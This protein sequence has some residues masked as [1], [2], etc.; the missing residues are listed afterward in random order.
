MD[1]RFAPPPAALPRET[2]RAILQQTQPAWEAPDLL[3]APP[4]RAR[5]PWLVVAA[6]VIL[7]LGAMGLRYFV[8]PPRV[9]PISL[10]VTEKDGQLEIQWNPLAK[11][12]NGATRGSLAIVDGKDTRTVPL[13]PQDLSR[14]SYAYQRTSGDV[15]VR[16]A[17]E[18][19]SGE[20]TEEAS[21]Y[22]GRPLVKEDS[23]ELKSL[24]QQR[25]D[26]QAEVQ[27]LRQENAT[28]NE[29]IQQL[30]RTLRILQ[31]RLGVK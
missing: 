16:L 10:A 27:R 19:A 3:P 29:R 20:K 25:D 15:E 11:A 12:M 8:F 30:D 1:R 4:P 13:A 14:G 31:T 9:E 26:L 28:Q 21:R 24:Q 22:L 6:I 23:E 7:A 5:W 18:N 2:P 17:V